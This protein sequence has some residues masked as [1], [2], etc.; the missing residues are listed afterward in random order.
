MIV[1]LDNGHGVNTAGKRSPDGRLREWSYTREI[2]KRIEA[3]LISMGIE[4]VRIVPED[5][6][7]PLNSGAD[8]RVRR[9]NNICKQRGSRNCLLVSVHCNAAGNKGQWM[10]ARGWS[11]FVAQ[12]ASADSKKLA[13]LLFD[14]AKKKGLKMRQPMPTQKF[15]VKSLAMCRD[16]NC[17]AVLTENLFQDN[18]ADVE[19]LLSEAGKEA[20]AELHVE[21]IMKYIFLTA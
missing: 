8:N 5:R 17:P 9:V 16:T 10:T 21:G 11:V 2:T 15:W 7:I 4:V 6:D 20:I 12:N 19:Y 3:K 18:L 14:E 13:D 1:L